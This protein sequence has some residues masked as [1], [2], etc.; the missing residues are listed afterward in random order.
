MANLGKAVKGKSHLARKAPPK[1][2]KP[3]KA[4]A[5]GQSDLSKALAKLQRRMMRVCC[6]GDVPKLT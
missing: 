2:S 6:V 3:A 1:E 4:R 5:V